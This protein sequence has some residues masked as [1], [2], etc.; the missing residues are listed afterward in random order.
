MSIFSWAVVAH[1]F[2]SQHLRGR[3]RRISKFEA[4]LQSKFQ[5]S[6]DYTEKP[7]LQKQNRNNTTTTIIINKNVHFHLLS[8]F[9]VQRK[10][11]ALLA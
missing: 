10:P 7:C 5:N 3:D 11:R 9:V 6:Q 2:K 4:S 1:T 8:L